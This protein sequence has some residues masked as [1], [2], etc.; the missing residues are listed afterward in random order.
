[1][2]YVGYMCV[3]EGGNGGT[4]GTVVEMRWW[5]RRAF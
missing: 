3:F 5:K 2:I 1:M 4:G